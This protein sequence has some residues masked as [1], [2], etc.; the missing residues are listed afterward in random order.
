MSYPNENIDE[1]EPII[2]PD[3]PI[4]DCHHHLWDGPHGRYLLPE[5]AADTRAGHNI[6]STMFV[7]CRAMYRRAGPHH[8]RSVGEAEFA[9][10][11]AAMG[12]SGNY[13]NTDFCAGFIGYADLR[14]GALLDKTI[15]ALVSASG[16]RLRGIR[17][18]VRWSEEEMPGLPHKL[19][20]PGL[21]QDEDF[22]RGFA[23]L[24]KYGLSFDAFLIHPQL[25][26]LLDLARAVPATQVVINHI[27]GP[28]GFGPYAAQCDDIMSQWTKQMT[29]L[30]ELD[31]IRVKI[32][33]LSMPFMGLVPDG[34]GRLSSARLAALWRPYVNR[35]IDIFGPARSMFESNF[36]VDG[37]SCG[38]P[39][40]WNAFKRLAADFT[41]SEKAALFFETAKMT[42]RL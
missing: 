37:R 11:M 29:A 31:N 42:Y 38:Y 6:V 22:R 1:I 19:N 13:G 7:E 10:G 17:Q 36:P 20:P 34:E 25:D 9:A 8:L 28:L 12:A 5:F 40:L 26:D 27:G 41:A 33:G 15:E 30:A 24:A 18:P 2:E 23:R 3:L 35:C 21:M 39:A 4:I 32:G 16:G 14:S